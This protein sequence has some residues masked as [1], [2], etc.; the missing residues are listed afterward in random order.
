MK[1]GT[2]IGFQH[3][4]RAKIDYKSDNGCLRDPV[5]YR[6]RHE[7]HIIHGNKYVYGNFCFLL[8]LFP[9]YLHE[10]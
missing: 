3:A 10:K 1:N 6:C 9:Y 8:F 2:A 5:L 7:E 4:L